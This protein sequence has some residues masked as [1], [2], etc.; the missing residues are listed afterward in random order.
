L[1]WGVESTR[2]SYFGQVSDTAAPIFAPA[3]F[4]DWQ[5]SGA[6]LT[7]LLAKEMVVST[8]A[9]IYVGEAED[10]E[11]AVPPTFLDDIKQITLGFVTAT[12]DAGKELIE[13]LT[14]GLTIFAADDDGQNTALTTALQAA[15]TPLTAFAFMVFVLLYI[16]CI[17][18]ISA[19]AHEFGWRWALFS[20]TIMLTVPWMLAVLI[21]Q[22]G[23]LLGVA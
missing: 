3:G 15:F 16:P 2:E 22:G 5:Q 20:M 9:Q 6:L 8:M 1:P 17:A 19:Q 13:T 4:G 14:P 23:K 11:T 12:I 7:G 21:Y 18:T 10:G